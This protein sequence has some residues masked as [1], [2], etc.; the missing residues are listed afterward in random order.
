MSLLIRGHFPELRV[1]KI[2]AF[3]NDIKLQIEH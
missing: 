3:I 1:K 2:T